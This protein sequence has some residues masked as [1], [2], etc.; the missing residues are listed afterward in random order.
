MGILEGILSGGGLGIFGGLATE[1]FKIFKGN[2]EHKQALAVKKLDLQA[3]DKRNQFAL[4]NF[5]LEMDGRKQELDAQ[6]EI[7]STEAHTQALTDSYAH[8]QSS[9]ETNG[10]S[11]LIWVEVIRKL[12]RPFLTGFLTVCVMAIYFTANDPEIEMQIAIG[13]LTAATSA[14]S[15]WFTSSHIGRSK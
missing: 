12:T 6:S 3:E 11:R 14:F 7:A 1:G 9:I 10:D 5:K 4:D 13:V 15:W 2:Q 8:D